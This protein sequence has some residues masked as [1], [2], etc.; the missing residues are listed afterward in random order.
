[1]N[2]LSNS[3]GRHC[4]PNEGGGLSKTTRLVASL[5][6]GRVRAEHS[7]SW[8]NGPRNT[9][10]RAALGTP[11]QVFEFFGTRWHLGRTVWG[12]SEGGTGG[13]FQLARVR[14]RRAYGTETA[15]PGPKRAPPD[16]RPFFF[17]RT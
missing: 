7:W 3:T 9:Q 14:F 15:V 8:L 16:P 12:A 13:S 2:L 5:L 11:R 10:G 6:A 1:M 17:P 4:T